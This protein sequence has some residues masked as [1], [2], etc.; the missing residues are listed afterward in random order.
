MTDPDKGAN[1]I[2][3]VMVHRHDEGFVVGAK[4]R[5]QFGRSISDFQN[6][7]FMLAGYP[8]DFPVERFMRDAKITRSTRAPTR[9][10][11]S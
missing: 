5:K 2:S 8:T 4:E 9:F 10:S 1:G 6:T 11:A 3:A 7:Q